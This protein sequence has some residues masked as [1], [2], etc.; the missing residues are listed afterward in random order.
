MGLLTELEATGLRRGYTFNNGKHLVTYGQLTT[1][2]RVAFGSR[3]RYLFGSGIQQEFSLDDPWFQVVSRELAALFPI[4]EG[5][6]FTHAW[7]GAMGVSRSLMPAVCFDAATGVGWAGGYFGD[8][9]GATN[10]A[11]RTLA[12]LV[13]GRNTERS[14]ALWVNPERE[15]SLVRRLWE[16]EPWRWLGIYSRYLW[17]GWTDW[18]E[19]R[20]SA[21]APVMNWVL[22]KVFP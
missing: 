15:Q 17:M 19:A 21:L 10:L 8:G 18:A 11:G 1:D 14:R 12:D 7:G 5:K 6:P 4:L 22:E 2:G 3:G 16:P 20:G 13:L 9:V